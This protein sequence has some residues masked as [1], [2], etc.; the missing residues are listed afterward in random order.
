M[1]V[2]VAGTRVPYLQHSNGGELTLH[3]RSLGDV[4]VSSNLVIQVRDLFRWAGV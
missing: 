3:L 2:V 1:L 4:S